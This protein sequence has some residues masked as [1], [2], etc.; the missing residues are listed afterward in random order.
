MAVG[1]AAEDGSPPRRW[2]WSRLSAGGCFSR[3]QA[4]DVGSAVDTFD[5]V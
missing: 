4:R 5:A 1:A 3:R 2:R